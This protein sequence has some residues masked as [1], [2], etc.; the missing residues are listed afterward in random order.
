MDLS[1][2]T[3]GLLRREFRD[4][5]AMISRMDRQVSRLIG[6]DDTLSHHQVHRPIISRR[7]SA[8]G[9]SR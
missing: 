2:D 1:S 9:T 6:P 3:V 4:T 7:P 5:H 8:H